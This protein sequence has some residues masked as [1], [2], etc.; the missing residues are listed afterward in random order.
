MT[1]R[2]K[3]EGAKGGQPFVALRKEGST[4]D[5]VNENAPP[6]EEGRFLLTGMDFG[7]KIR[8]SPPHLRTM[9]GIPLNRQSD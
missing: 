9:Q 1:Q 3:K 8:C 2:D 4:T 7:V 5:I 6:D